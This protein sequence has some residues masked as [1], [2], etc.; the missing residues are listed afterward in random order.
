[1]IDEDKSLINLVC[2]FVKQNPK[3]IQEAEAK[4]AKE[5]KKEAKI[6]LMQA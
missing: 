3:H 5:A 2:Q 4:A 1:M 6:K